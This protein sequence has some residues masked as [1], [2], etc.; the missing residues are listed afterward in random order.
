MGKFVKG[1]PGKPIGSKN[2]ITKSV[3]ETFL[4]IFNKLQEDQSEENPANLFN[5]AKKNP[6][7]FY[8]LAAKLIPT[9]ITAQ[10]RQTIKV[11]ISKKENGT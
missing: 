4:E 11:S 9:E 1:N 7:D 2:K 5:W 10:I 6:R 3:K 8:P